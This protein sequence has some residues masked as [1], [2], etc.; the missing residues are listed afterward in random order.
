[1]GLAF[2]VALA[3]GL[4]IYR[5]VKTNQLRGSEATN[6]LAA[7]THVNEKFMDAYYHHH[8]HHSVHKGNPMKKIVEVMGQCNE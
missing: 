5:F 4:I 8:H 3:V 1:M 6:T 7:V 2:L